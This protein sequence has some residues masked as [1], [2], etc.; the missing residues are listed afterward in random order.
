MKCITASL[1][2]VTL[3]L[4]V[5]A[6]PVPVTIGMPTGEDL[7]A[8]FA[9]AVSLAEAELAKCVASGADCSTFAAAVEAARAQ[10]TFYAGNEK[11]TFTMPPTTIAT[12]TTTGAPGA[13][14]VGALVTCALT[15]C[16]IQAMSC[17][18]SETCMPLVLG[19]AGIDTSGDMD[20]ILAQAF[21]MAEGDDT[22]K[23]LLDC[24]IE[25]CL[26]NQSGGGG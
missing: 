26:D 25:K 2:V 6:D 20:S 18:A 11:S 3:G 9:I 24:A 22:A 17:V 15:S 10:F 5:H 16:G 8:M 13:I 1:L 23:P 7:E 14:D 19:L 4:S 12:T 21:A